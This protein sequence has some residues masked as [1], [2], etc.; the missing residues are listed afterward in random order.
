MRIFF[1][2]CAGGFNQIF[3]TLVQLFGCGICVSSHTNELFKVT[4]H[5][6]TYNSPFEEMIVHVKFLLSYAP[7]EISEFKNRRTTINKTNLSIFLNK[8]SLSS[9]EIEKQT[10]K[11]EKHFYQPSGYFYRGSFFFFDEG[12]SRIARFLVVN[13]A[14]LNSVWRMHTIRPHIF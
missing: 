6:F 14:S 2:L 13:N 4:K 3:K 5:A 8:D 1:K 12:F 7:P 10:K 11:E 9:R